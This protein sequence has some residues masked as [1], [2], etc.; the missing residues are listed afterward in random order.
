MD[1]IESQDTSVKSGALS[2]F[3]PAAIL[4]TLVYLSAL[5]DLVWDWSND[6]NYSHGFFVPAISGYLIWQKREK[7]R[8]LTFQTD[9]RG[10]L[11][12]IAGLLLFVLGNGA[13]EYFSLR[14]S[15]VISLAGLTWYLF[16]STLV[17]LIWFEIFF[18]F[19]M[20]PI[21]YV[22]YFSATFP[23]QLL[24]SKITAG[25]MNLIGMGVVRQGNILHI[26][27]YSLEVAE[28]CSGIRS[29][30]S[31]LAL[32][33]LYAQITQKRFAGKALLFLSTIPIAVIGNVFRVMLTSLI[34]H[35]IT[36]AVTDEP[37]HSILGLTVFVVAFVL[38]FIFGA[39]LSRVLK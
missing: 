15:F 32:G 37:L 24:A 4:L 5:I 8:Q 11:L 23:M 39:V 30:I 36:T 16:G 10:L 3:V 7:I 28:A 13:A 12:L 35:T 34:A 22:I 25:V 31:L 2:L 29:L 27:G 26:Q 19:F 18:L 6:P 20:L 21:P 17:R 9:S 33:A 38:M 1:R 14:V